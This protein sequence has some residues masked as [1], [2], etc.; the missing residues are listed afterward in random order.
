MTDQISNESNDGPT[1]P[2]G[3]IELGNLLAEM[4]GRKYKPD[5]KRMM[6]TPD[7]AR[8][9]ANYTDR[10]QSH[11]T[12]LNEWWNEQFSPDGQATRRWTFDTFATEPELVAMELVQHAVNTMDDLVLLD[13]EKATA[14]RRVLSYV[15]ERV[16]LEHSRAV[17][18]R[19]ERDDG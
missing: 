9:I 11:V 6:I 2:R 15:Q 12:R 19:E 18:L 16:G 13:E 4:R 10:L 7:Q 3:S 8:E 14:K 17:K 5:P 1:F